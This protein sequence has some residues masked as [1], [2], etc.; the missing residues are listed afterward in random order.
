METSVVESVR[1]IPPITLSLLKEGN[2][3]LAKSRFSNPKDAIN[4]ALFIDFMAGN[5]N[6]NVDDL[7]FPDQGSEWKLTREEATKLFF[8]HLE[9]RT[10]AVDPFKE[11]SES[12]KQNIEA[13]YRSIYEGKM[14]S[15]KADMEIHVSKATDLQARAV[16]SLRIA[17]EKRCEIDIISG[18]NILDGFNSIISGLSSTNWNFHRMRG[19][20]LEFVSRSDI[21][22]RHI[23]QK[24]GLHYEINC[25]RFLASFGVKDSSFKILPHKN[26]TK[27]LYENDYIHPHIS[28]LGNVCWGNASDASNDAM[29]NGD[30]ITL[31][32]LLDNMLPHY[33]SESPY[34]AIDRFAEWARIRDERLSESHEQ[35]IKEKTENEEFSAHEDEIDWEPIGD[36]D[37]PDESNDMEDGGSDEL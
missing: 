34:I 6:A 28:R 5:N 20:I 24:A 14:E 33:N 37:E 10:A 2:Y 26:T 7:V 25:G 1:T 17:R 18:K 30:V 11:I 35:E 12:E 32:K 22:L 21:I 27:L 15:L 3:A 29:V 23:D 36:T 19:G 9:S 16:E 4:I 31:L 13:S 8:S